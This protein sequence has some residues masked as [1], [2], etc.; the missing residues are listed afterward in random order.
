MSMG[1]VLR[2]IK[3]NPL[4][5]VEK[6]QVGALG[7]RSP[8][9]AGSS[10]EHPRATAPADDRLPSRHLDRYRTIFS[11]VKERDAGLEGGVPRRRLEDAGET[12]WRLGL[13][14]WLA[15]HELPPGDVM[16]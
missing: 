9:G 2:T 1:L 3:C 10:K 15:Q 4:S 11:S 12:Q 8:D 13:R 7:Q 6:T 14:A 16:P 5:V